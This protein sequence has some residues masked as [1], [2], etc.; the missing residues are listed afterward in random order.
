ML[1]DQLQYFVAKN[2]NKLKTKKQILI[3]VSDS[4]FSIV[5]QCVMF[6]FSLNNNLSD[7]KCKVLVLWRRMNEPWGVH[8]H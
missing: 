5:Q 1:N 8:L 6:L 3:C 4:I 7:T 2:R